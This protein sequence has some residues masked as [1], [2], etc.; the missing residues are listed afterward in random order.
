MEGNQNKNTF[1]QAYTKFITSAANHKTLIA[2]F[3]PALS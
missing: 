1:N 3:I 2:P